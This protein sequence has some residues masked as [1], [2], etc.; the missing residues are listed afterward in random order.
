MTLREF[1]VRRA[2]R[3]RWNQKRGLESD[4]KR[5]F[6]GVFA[7]FLPSFYQFLPEFLRSFTEFLE[8]LL[9]QFRI[10]FAQ[11]RLWSRGSW[12]SFE[13]SNIEDSKWVDSCATLY[14]TRMHEIYELFRTPAKESDELYRPPHRLIALSVDCIRLL[15]VLFVD[16]RFY[17]IWSWSRRSQERE[18][19]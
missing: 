9:F 14:A 10:P 8:F 5:V 19:S 17:W 4:V 7:E 13:S 18:R 11:K 6:Y 2:S 1:Q 15:S 12:S 16:I 3:T